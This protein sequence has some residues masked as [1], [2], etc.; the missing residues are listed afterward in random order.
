VINQTDYFKEG[1][2]V[3]KLGLGGLSLQE[4]DNYLTKGF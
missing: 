1:R 2:T 3:E 4:L